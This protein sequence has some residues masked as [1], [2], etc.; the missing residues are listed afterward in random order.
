M[1][2]S[3]QKHKRILMFFT[4]A[5]VIPSFVIT[6]VYSWNRMTSADNAVATIGGESISPQQLD[7]A[8]RERGEQLRQAL[9]NNYDPKM[10]DSPAARAAVLE[11]MLAER[12][13]AMAARK[14][15]AFV[16]DAY[17]REV[18]VQVPQFQNGGKFSYDTYKTILA[19][20]GMNEYIFEQRVR[21]DLLRQ[22]LAR[23]VS[24]SAIVPKF[25]LDRINRLDEEQREV[26]V[27][28]FKA[29]DYLSQVNVTAQAINAY[30]ESNRAGFQTPE[31]VKAEYV[32]LALDDVA[33]HIAAP[34]AELKTYYEQNQSRFGEVEQR[35]AA[36]ILITSGDSGSAKDKAGALKIAE[37]VLAKARARPDS[38]A[39]LAKE[40]SKDPGSA[41]NGGDL[42]MF[43]R[44]M[45][46]KPFEEAVFKLKQGDISDIVES[47]FG[48]H[49]IKLTA[50][51]PASVKPFE[52]VRAELGKD[53]QRQ[54]AQK[55]FAE[56]VETFTNTVYEQ[57]DSLKPV[58]EKLN[59]TIRAAAVVPKTGLPAQPNEPQYFSPR[60][61]QALFSTDA[62]NKKHNTEAIEVAPNTFVSARVVEHH[63]A[64]LR[65]LPEVQDSIKQML[66]AQEAANLARAAAVKT[67]ATL[68]QAPSDA[69]F[70]APITI[71]RTQAHNL[72][73][74]AV[75]AA[76][77]APADKLPVYVDSELEKGA[78]GIVQV[79]GVKASE[80]ANSATPEQREA[81]KQAL[82][83]QFEAVDDRS[84]LDA[85]KT[86]YKAQ[87]LK[88]DLS[89]AAPAES[90]Q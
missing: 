9:G 87:V 66:V 54:Q 89:V 35:Q 58:A 81:R 28:R 78:Y 14:D 43:G 26:R 5:L 83:R 51:K 36:H 31:T 41:A 7:A 40:Y 74:Q 77:R 73:M 30:Y 82:L 23:A 50:V 76:M 88:T 90:P 84:Y 24:D 12:S 20:Q 86:K 85:L 32:V 10:L 18:I 52:Q 48:Y 63:P 68:K 71:S 44:G 47:D 49:I 65:P 19:S 80:P 62:I 39:Q 69:G 56:A 45:M 6:G 1:F 2:E 29:E 17:V 21:D 33:A 3:I 27:R 60:V 70:D 46:V 4:S 64:A 25:V 37:E 59:L 13:L 15:N 61:V 16:S 8:L 75:L 42:G 38:F 57:A 53:Y 55:K 22:T 72:P 11:G 79:L 67:M 34:E